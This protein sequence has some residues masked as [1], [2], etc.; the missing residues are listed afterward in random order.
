[1]NANENKIKTKLVIFDFD[2]TLSKPDK[3]NNT[4]ARIWNRIDMLDEDD[5]LYELYKNRSF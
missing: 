1:M 2:G 3:I 4:W 5:R